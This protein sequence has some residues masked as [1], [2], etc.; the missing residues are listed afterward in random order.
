VEF[1][2]IEIEKFL[3]KQFIQ[4]KKIL[5]DEQKFVKFTFEY[6]RG[7]NSTLIPN[8][9]RKIP[10]KT[11]SQNQKS[12]INLYINNPKKGEKLVSTLNKMIFFLERNKFDNDC[13][14]I[15]ATEKMSKF[16]EI[17]KNIK[18]FFKNNMDFT[19][20]YIIDIYN[21][22]E[23]Q[24][25]DYIREHVS[26][27]YKI[28]LTEG[29]KNRINNFFNENGDSVLT[30]KNLSTAIRQFI[31]RFLM[32]ED[33]FDRTKEITQYIFEYEDIWESE[34][35]DKISDMDKYN[36]IN[37]DIK[38]SEAVNFYDFLGGDKEDIV[39]V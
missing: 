25:F 4:G 3:S 14:L 21:F 8:F 1:D 17:E 12:A 15:N 33:D 9:K 6:F 22:T 7:D 2:F 16:L 5:S 28:E 18:E 20:E 10:Q 35:F 26:N 19:L 23:K 30:K 27:D 37:I 29:K 36:F 34:I 13:T 31:S 39:I 32:K 38:I 11:I 24:I